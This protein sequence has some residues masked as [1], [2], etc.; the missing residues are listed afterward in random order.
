MRSRRREDPL[1][2]ACW[3]LEATGRAEP[4]L[5]LGGARLARFAQDYPRTVMLAR[6]A[7]AAEPSA[8]AGLVLGEALYNLGSFQEAEVALAAATERASGDA[9]VVRIATVRRRNLLRG[10]RRDAEALDVGRAAAAVVVSDEARAELLA[11]EAEILAVSGR[12]MEALALLA[13]LPSSSPRVHVLAAIARASALATIGRT[14]EAISVS[15]QAYRDHLAL[16][17]ELAI[18]SPGTHRVNQLFALVQA[19]RLVEAD[20]KGRAWFDVVERARNPLGVMWLGVHL[21]RCA[22]IHGR[23]ATVLRW[24]QRACT[25]IDSSGF[26]GL[27]PV[28]YSIEAVAYGLL[29]DGASSVARADLVDSLEAGFGFLQDELALGRAWASS[30]SASWAPPA[31]CSWRRPGRRRAPVTSPRRRGCCT[32]PPGWA[33]IT[34]RRPCW[35]TWPPRPTALWLRL[36]P[37]MRLPSSPVTASDSRPPA[38]GSQR[39]ALTCSRRSRC[40][41]PL[42]SGDGGGTSEGRPRSTSASMG[43]RRAVR[44]RGLRR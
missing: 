38:T 35:P 33:V 12:A 19:G 39:S 29:G 43:S 27:R 44:V 37:N 3:R 32:T 13:Q 28:V 14:A 20:E 34:T 22:L 18:S 31:T 9:E 15:K 36:A 17:D 40:V 41:Q 11:G 7:L 24:T 30:P 25:A 8:E 5:L 26:E 4:E 21:A 16:G 10:C 1:R 42:T 2:I 23:P 6:A